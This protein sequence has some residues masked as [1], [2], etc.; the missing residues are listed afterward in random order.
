MQLRHY[1]ADPYSGLLAHIRMSSPIETG[2]DK[3]NGLE[4]SNPRV[5]ICGRKTKIL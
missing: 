2:L 3:E 1:V 4:F 5:A